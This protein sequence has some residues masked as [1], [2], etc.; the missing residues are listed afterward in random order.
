[1]TIMTLP[2]I[3]SLDNELTVHC[4]NKKI[5]INAQFICGFLINI[6]PQVHLYSEQ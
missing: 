4:S 5:I 1:M 6:I 2:L 3:T